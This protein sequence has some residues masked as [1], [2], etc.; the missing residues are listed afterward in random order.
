MRVGEAQAAHLPITVYRPADPAS[1]D[2]MALADELRGESAPQ[3][4]ETPAKPTE[5]P[6]GP[7]KA[8]TKAPETAHAA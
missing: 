4:T 3:S 2:Y 8:I 1:R 5:A 7:A 6:G